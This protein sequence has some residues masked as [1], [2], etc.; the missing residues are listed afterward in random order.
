MGFGARHLGG[1]WLGALAVWVLGGFAGTGWRRRV[2]S[3]TACVSPSP[4]GRVEL[5][6]LAWGGGGIWGVYLGG[7]V[8]V[9]LGLVLMRAAWKQH[10]RRDAEK[11]VSF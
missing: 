1:I 6:S 8:S 11:L 9:V 4:P 2:R 7:L 3:G 5:V 10:L